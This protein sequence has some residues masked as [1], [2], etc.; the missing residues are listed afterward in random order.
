MLT[1]SSDQIAEYLNN[2]IWNFKVGDN[3]SYNLKLLFALYKL[4]EKSLRNGDLLDKFVII[5]IV[6]IIEC[7]L[8]DFIWR[9]K[10]ATLHYP[11]NISQSERGQISVALQN[12]M[13]K[14]K[15]KNIK[16]SEITSFLHKYKLF[17]NN[18]ELYEN[19]EELGNLRNRIHIFNYYSVLEKDEAFVYTPLRVSK[20]E[21]TLC[22]VIS[23][24]GVNYPRPWKTETTGRIS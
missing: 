8:T 20:A 7:L 15:L 5:Q 18:Q 17:G 3:L 1:L 23:Y 4:K 2:V 22:E 10:G 13:L 12:W 19:L 24:M 16:F 9:L 14:D 6:S 11:Q 21:K